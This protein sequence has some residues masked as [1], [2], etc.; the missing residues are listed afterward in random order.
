MSFVLPS[1]PYEYQ[2]LEP[3]IDRETMCIHHT[4]HHQT[5]VTKLNEALM[6]NPSGPSFTDAALLQCEIAKQPVAVRNNGGG[7]YN[8]SLFWKWMC[9]VGSSNS[10]PTGELKVSINET[11]G[12]FE[13]MKKQFTDSASARFGS[14]WAWLGVKP[15]GHLAISS[16][17]NQDNPLMKGLVDTEM[18]PILGLDVWEHA[19][20]LKYQNKRADYIQQWWNVVNWDLVVEGY[21]KFASRQIPLPT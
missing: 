10:A 6:Q 13:E 16:T 17:P 21:E 12:S 9:P 15:D 7:H 19:Y 8:H 3:Y 11:F 18:I 4:K 1:L 14:G 2:V 20:Y 5:Y